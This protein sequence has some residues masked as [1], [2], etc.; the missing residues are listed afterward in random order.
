M[1]LCF[2]AEIVDD[3]RLHATSND[4]P[5]GADI[6]LSESGYTYTPYVIL[7][8][9]GSFRVRL[10]CR[11]V[12]VVDEDGVIRDRVDMSWLGLP[13]ATLTVTIQ[14]DRSGVPPPA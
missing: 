3:R 8:R 12:N 10:R 1:R 6:I 9:R 11:D 14:V 2:A 13:Q 4:T 5:G 7:A